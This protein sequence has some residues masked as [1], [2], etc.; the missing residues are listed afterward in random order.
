MPLSPSRVQRIPPQALYFD[1]VDDYVSIPHSSSLYFD[2]DFTVMVA[3]MVPVP[4]MW[5][6]IVDKGRNYLS[7]WWLLTGKETCTVLWGIGF[8]DNTSLEQWLPAPNCSEWIVL[9]FGVE[10][11]N[12]F[13]SVNG[14]NKVY[15]SF[16]KTRKVGTYP[17][18]IGARTPGNTFA[19]VYVA[20]LVAYKG[21]AL[22]RDEIL[23]NFNYPD[24]PIR[25][26]LVLW[27]HW[28]S[29]DPV[30]GIWYDKSGFGNHG[31]IYGA[32]LVKIVKPSRRVLTPSRVLAPRR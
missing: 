19:R 10:G 18:T 20:W 25:N 3:F 22:S 6:G 16:G 29:I 23:W 17:L 5:A 21:R 31:T 13:Y 11:N 9:A 4:Q 27:L 1:G 7:D 15:T 2:S 24:N 32:T 30:A 26:G 14:G 12:M 8:T 28:D